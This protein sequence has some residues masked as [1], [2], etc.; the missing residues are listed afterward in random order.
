MFHQMAV[1]LPTRMAA[2]KRRIFVR[3]KDGHGYLRLADVRANEN[4]RRSG[5][6]LGSD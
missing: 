4:K 1:V 6:E 3:P 5:K 2:G